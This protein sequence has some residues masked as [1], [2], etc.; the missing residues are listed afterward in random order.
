MGIKNL[1]VF[2]RQRFPEIFEEIHISEY[3]YKKIAIDISLYLCNYKAAFG[4]GWL[5]AFVKLV[6]T[7]RANEV[8]CVFVYDGKAP[9][10]K[11]DERKERMESRAKMGDRIYMLREAIERYKEEGVIDP[12]LTEFQEKRKIEHKSLMREG[13]INIRAIEMMVDKME[14]QMFALTPEDF[15]ATK[16][17]FRILDVPYIEAV[18]EGEALCSDLCIQ[19]KVDA[20]LSEDT[21]VLAYGAPFFL[22]KMDTRNATCVRIDYRKLLELVGLSHSEFLDFCIMCKTDYNKNIP[23]IGC[24]NAYKYILEYKTIEA[25]QENLG[26]DVTCLR[27]VRNRELFRDYVRYGGKISYCGTPDFQKLQEFIFRR[28]LRIGVDSLRKSFMPPEIVVIED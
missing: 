15:A 20:V 28:N 4:D 16:E 24:V 7:L 17:L 8:H 22:T 25:I 21:D 6:S 14:K 12:I 10:D 27:H 18:G 23:K 3:Q 1:S 9:P 19:G 13:G 5:G 26:V 11:E 2:L